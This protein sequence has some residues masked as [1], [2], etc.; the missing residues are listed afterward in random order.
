MNAQVEILRSKI[1]SGHHEMMAITD[2]HSA[3]SCQYRQIQKTLDGLENEL[4]AELSADAAGKV[5]ANDGES[6]EIRSISGRVRMGN[7]VRA[8][9]SGHAPS[10]AELELNQAYEIADPDRF[11]LTLLDPASW[12][13]QQAKT[14]ADGASRQSTWLDRLFAD[15]AA[16]HVGVTFESVKPGIQSY[17]VTTAGA[18]AAQR[19]RTE[20]AA[21][22]SWTIGVTELKPTR[23]A[24]RVRFSDE[25]MYRLPTL[26]SALRRDLAMSLVEGLDRTIFTGD[27]DANENTADITGF[28]GITAAATGLVEKT[29]TQTDK[30]KAPETLAVFAGFIDGKHASSMSDLRVVASVGANTLWLSQIAAAA[31]DTKTVA[32]FMKENGLMWMTRGEIETATGNGKFG[33]IIGKS[34]GIAGAAMAPV[35]QSGRLIRD[36]YSAA[37]SGECSLTL[38]TFWN[39]GLVR[40]SN[41]AR[42][43]FVT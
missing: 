7:Y 40:P 22:A 28:T 37:A 15:S 11:P 42:L 20:K 24:V 3:N 16:A 19:G 38:A 29:L 8:V 32:Q 18:A 17:P 10:G 25:D 35:W 27:A 34:R 12:S 9:M 41:F 36:V 4:Q 13:P 21:D 2:R 26:E 6:A 1:R 30:V 14:D 5:F 33:A 31:A 23:N 39:F 43:K